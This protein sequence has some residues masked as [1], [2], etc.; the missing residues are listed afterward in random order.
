MAAKEFG[1]LPTD[2]EDRMSQRWWEFWKL[3]RI[4]TSRKPETVQ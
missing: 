4:E 2:V 3:M 1:V